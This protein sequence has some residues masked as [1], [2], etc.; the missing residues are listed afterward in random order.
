MGDGLLSTTIDDVQ[1]VD[2][3]IDDDV[4]LCTLSMMFV[5]VHRQGM[6]MMLD[7]C[8]HPPHS[9]VFEETA[10]ILS[11]VL[12]YRNVCIIIIIIITTTIILI[13]RPKHR[14]GDVLIDDD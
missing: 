6:C 1:T 3:V 13:G 7:F 10:A 8:Y 5:G 12:W 9:H 14:D 11:A 2:Y 4:R